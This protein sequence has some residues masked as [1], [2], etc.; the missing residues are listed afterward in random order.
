MHA[1]GIEE[2]ALVAPIEAVSREEIAQNLPSVPGDAFRNPTKE[3]N[4]VWYRGVFGSVNIQLKSKYLPRS[5][6]RR[7][8]TQALTNEKTISITP[9]YLRKTFELQFLHSFGRISRTLSTYPI[10]EY[11]APIFEIIRKGD[12]HG[13][14]LALSSGSV[15]PFALSENGLSLLHV[16]ASIDRY[17]V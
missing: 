3:T 15:S 14:Q 7:S 10:L 13:L 8:G 5:N 6:A 4:L 9:I 16:S 11:R 17:V 12:L 2:S 1:T